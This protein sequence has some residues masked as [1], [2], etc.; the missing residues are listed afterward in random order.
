V[1]PGG[2]AVPEL[3]ILGVAI[4]DCRMADALAQIAEWLDDA[5]GRGHSVFFVNAHTLNLACDDPAYRAVLGT[6]DAVYG[7]GTGVR[8][9]ARVLHGVRL[10]D[11]VNGTDL[12]PALF[13]AGAGKGLRYY[14]LGG[15]EEQSERA[16]AHAARTFEGWTLAGHHHGY[17][18][19]AASARV[20]DAIHAAKP[21]LL[22]VGMGN[23]FQERWIAANRERLRVPVAIGVGGL[24]TYWSGHLERAPAWVRGIGFEWLHLLIRQP[25]KGRRYLLGNPVF[26][27]RLVAQRWRHRAS[28]T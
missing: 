19:D 12:V 15:T 13:S 14:M 23:P 2:V 25:Q 18:D 9:A 24:F 1:T 3:D 28:R 11:N 26:L 27:G 16:S 8:W 17:L 20:I 22:L 10:A 4:R 7:D 5:S 21:H 6:S